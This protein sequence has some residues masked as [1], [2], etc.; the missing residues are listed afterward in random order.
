MWKPSTLP[1]LCATCGQQIARA[2][3]VSSLLLMP[4]HQVLET[5]HGAAI[6]FCPLPVLKSSSLFIIADMYPI[7]SPF[8]ENKNLVMFIFL[9]L[10][11]LPPSLPGSLLQWSLLSAHV[12]RK[13]KFRSEE[14]DTVTLGELWNNIP[15]LLFQSHAL[16]R[17]LLPEVITAQPMMSTPWTVSST[18]DVRRDTHRL[19]MRQSSALLAE[20]GYRQ[21]MR[22]GVGEMIELLLI[23]TV[24]VTIVQCMFDPHPDLV[25][26][27]QANNEYRH[28]RGK[29]TLWHWCTNQSQTCGGQR[30]IMNIDVVIRILVGNAENP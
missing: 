16:R 7:Y 27:S 22:P 12:Q 4:R 23:Q 17:S 25:R 21:D 29:V 30:Q 14:T 18:L 2:N 19:W 20:S 9:L 11:F 13:L 10:F 26:R 1:V 28:R 8:I 15:P 6:A 24:S 5:N 3:A